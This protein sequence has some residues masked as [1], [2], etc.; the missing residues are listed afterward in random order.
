[1]NF[2]SSDCYYFFC[3][4]ANGLETGGVSLV[5]RISNA[6]VFEYCGFIKHTFSIA[7]CIKSINCFAIISIGFG[8]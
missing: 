6:C 5:E 4:I 7:I 8:I 3:F 1:M 2:L